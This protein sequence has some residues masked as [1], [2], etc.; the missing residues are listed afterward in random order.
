MRDLEVLDV[1]EEVAVYELFHNVHW[2]IALGGNEIDVKLAVSVVQR[3]EANPAFV[4][5]TTFGKVHALPSDG[6]GLLYIRDQVVMADTDALGQTRRAGAVVD[7]RDGFDCLLASQSPPLIGLG[8][9]RT[10]DHLP[11]VPDSVHS[12]ARLV[13]ELEDPFLRQACCFRGRYSVW[14]HTWVRE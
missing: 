1:P 10:G 14:N 2:D 8:F 6:D 12:R 5:C 3:Q 7:R 11:P 4:D 9:L 13:V